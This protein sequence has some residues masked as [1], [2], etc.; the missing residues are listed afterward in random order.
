MRLLNFLS[1][2]ES[3][4]QKLAGMKDSIQALRDKLIELE[5]SLGD[6]ADNDETKKIRSEMDTVKGN[7][8][9]AKLKL[10]M[11]KDNGRLSK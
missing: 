8:K 4:S 10:E 7:I 2:E 6:A 11:T 5:N 1:E 3:F 9:I